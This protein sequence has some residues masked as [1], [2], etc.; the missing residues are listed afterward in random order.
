MHKVKLLFY[1]TILNLRYTTLHLSTFGFLLL[2]EIIM[3]IGDFTIFLIF[4]EFLIYIILIQLVSILWKRIKPILMKNQFVL[5]FVLCS[6]S[7][8]IWLSYFEWIQPF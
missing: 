5:T 2:V 7:V 4:P 3:G 6:F 8:L 1:K